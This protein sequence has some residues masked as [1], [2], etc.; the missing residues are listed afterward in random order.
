MPWIAIA[1]TVDNII[2][3]AVDDITI[4]NEAAE[5]DFDI[6]VK[7]YGISDKEYVD[8]KAGNFSWRI[9]FNNLRST[10]LESIKKTSHQE[11]LTKIY[12][13]RLTQ[14]T[15][16]RGRFEHA[17]NKHKPLLSQ[18]LIIYEAKAKEAND[19]IEHG[20]FSLYFNDGYIKDYAEE[21]GLDINI[22]AKLVLT[23]YNNW[24]EYLR[25]LERL[26]LRHVVAIKKSKTSD[27]FSKV[28]AEIDKDFF[29]NMLL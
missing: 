24:H 5:Y 1:S 2:I 15:N 19:I 9:R 22:A 6:I 14:L 4:L 20:L 18:Q 29:V 12:I 17:L 16:I 21:V 7:I 25:K 28:I 23:K 3:V 11:N 8:L 13:Q 27:D 10:Y 26:R